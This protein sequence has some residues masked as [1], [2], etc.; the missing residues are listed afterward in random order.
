MLFIQNLRPSS[1]ASEITDDSALLQP[2]RESVVPRF[3]WRRVEGSTQWE[4]GYGQSFE[5]IPHG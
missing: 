4:G 1:S 5:C 3:I 2:K